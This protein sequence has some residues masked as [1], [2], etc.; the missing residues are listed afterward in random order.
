MPVGQALDVL[1]QIHKVCP[2]AT[3]YISGDEPTLHA[4]FHNIVSLALELFK[5]V[6]VI[7]NG[8]NTKKIITCQNMYPKLH[9]QFSLDGTESIH[10]H[11]RG[12]N[13]FCN[14]IQTLNYFSENDLD[15]TI[16]TTVS[17]DNVAYI[18]NLVVTQ[19]LV[20]K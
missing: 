1:H 17:L 14:V 12:A 20:V 18:K 3:V 11:L 4:N 8:T 9:F 6:W 5:N 10:N 19:R 15:M 2:N 7:S 13:S 16:S